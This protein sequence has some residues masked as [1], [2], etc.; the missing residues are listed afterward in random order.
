[1]SEYSDYQYVEPPKPMK[2]T[3]TQKGDSEIYTHPAFGM[4]SAHHINSSSP[5]LVQISNT[6]E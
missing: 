2:P 4:V 5:S 1:M 3:V 6:K